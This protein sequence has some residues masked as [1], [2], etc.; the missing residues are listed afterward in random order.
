MSRD[1][2]TREILGSGKKSLWS[3]SPKN[4]RR[5][6]DEDKGTP[7]NA[8]ILCWNIRIPPKNEILPH[9]RLA[10]MVDE[11]PCIEETRRRFPKKWFPPN[12]TPPRLFHSGPHKRVIERNGESN[13]TNLNW[14]GRHEQR[15]KYL[16][17]AT[18]TLSLNSN[19]T[20]PSITLV[21]VKLDY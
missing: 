17:L 14:K 4:K 13:T 15:S 16:G 7:I 12:P 2:D 3:D 18:L 10:P 6:E 21:C 20:F 11:K 1:I 19:Q 9:N 8:K 5:Y